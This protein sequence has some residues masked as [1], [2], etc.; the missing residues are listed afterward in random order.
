MINFVFQTSQK[1]KD[2]IC[3]HFK[4]ITVEEQ[5][6]KESILILEVK[7]SLDL[8]IEANRDYDLV[9]I[10]SNGDLIFDILELRPKVILRQSKLE[11]DLKLLEELLQDNKKH[12]NRIIEFK[13]GYLNVRLKI[14]TIV[15]IESFG[16]YLQVHT[17]NG[18]FVVRDQLRDVLKKLQGFTFKQIHKSYI[19]NEQYIQQISSKSCVLNNNVELPIGRRFKGV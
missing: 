15:Y 2:L 7:N 9:V 16:H 5:L 8:K 18:Q 19:V 1:T 11:S 17:L 13:S 10:I 6:N 14:D 3:R 12:M 4:E